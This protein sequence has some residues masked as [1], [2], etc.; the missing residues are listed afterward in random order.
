MPFDGSNY[1]I[2]ARMRALFGPNGEH[3]RKGAYWDG[4]NMCLIGALE[5]VMACDC[6]VVVGGP[7]YLLLCR[8]IGPRTTVVERYNDRPQRTFKDI[9][10]V[11]NRMEK[12]ELAE[13]EK[14]NAV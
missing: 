9:Q 14:V 10:R 2:A 11:L 8:A 7:E 4:G 5:Q 12:L 13:K 1:T 3:W 6:D